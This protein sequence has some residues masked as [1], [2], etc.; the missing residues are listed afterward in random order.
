MIQLHQGRFVPKSSLFSWACASLADCRVQIARVLCDR[1]VR[2][3][4]RRDEDNAAADAS[5]R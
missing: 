2:A 5:F 4:G 1:D 3:H